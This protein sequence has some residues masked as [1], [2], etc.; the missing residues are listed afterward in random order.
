MEGGLILEGV[1]F[2]STD[3]PTY[4]YDMKDRDRIEINGEWYVREHTLICNDVKR[5]AAV[6]PSDLVFSKV[7]TYEEGSFCFEACH[8]TQESGAPYGE[9]IVGPFGG[10]YV[11]FIDK[12][13]ER[14]DQWVDYAID[15]GHFFTGVLEENPDTISEC[16]KI[17]NQEQLDSFTALLRYIDESKWAEI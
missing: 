13:I 14:R 11:K 8:L 12:R 1:I 6:D 16:H 9:E 7:I 15:N 17:M 5:V 3:N 4:L 10:M 2:G